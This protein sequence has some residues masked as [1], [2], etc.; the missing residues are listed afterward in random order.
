MGSE[1]KAGTWTVV[2]SAFNTDLLPWRWNISSAYFI[3][4]RTVIAAMLTAYFGHGVCVLAY[5][6]YHHYSLKS[7]LEKRN[8]AVWGDSDL[9]KYHVRSRIK[10]VLHEHL[11]GQCQSHGRQTS[12][13][14][15]CSNT[16]S[17][18][19]NKSKLEYLMR[20]VYTRFILYQGCW[21]L[22]FLENLLQSQFTL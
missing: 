11:Q 15:I 3:F 5:L 7:G 16:Q 22:I 19:Q 8:V 9:F 13:H 6:I 12:T 4:I 2:L 18:K 10:H 1:V 14:L 17:E 21:Y 20:Q